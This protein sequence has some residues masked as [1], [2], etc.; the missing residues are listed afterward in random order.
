MELPGL[1]CLGIHVRLPHRDPACHVASHAV[2]REN[3]AVRL[4]TTYINA[5][6]ATNHHK[7]R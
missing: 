3:T 6:R 1:D 4:E 7:V 2:S 5:L